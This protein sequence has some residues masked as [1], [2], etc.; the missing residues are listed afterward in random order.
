MRKAYLNLH[1]LG[2]AHAVE[3]WDGPELVGGLYGIA[4]GGV[5]FGEPGMNSMM[6]VGLPGIYFCRNGTSARTRRSPVPPGS[7]PWTM[8]MVLPWKNGAWAK[9]GA[10]NNWQRSRI[11]GST[12]L[13]GLF[14]D[15]L[16][17]SCSTHFRSDYL[18]NTF[19]SC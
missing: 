9:A 12:N 2:Y 7:R 18:L 14:L 5:F 3:A 13:S 19:F 16:T 17:S 8:V 6:M 11:V 4:L 1:E 10:T 15:M